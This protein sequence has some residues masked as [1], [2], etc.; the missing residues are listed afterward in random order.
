LEKLVVLLSPEECAKQHTLPCLQEV[1]QQWRRSGNSSSAGRGLSIDGVGHSGTANS[2]P[3]PSTA[4]HSSSSR[5]Q[6]ASGVHTT[7]PRVQLALTGGMDPADTRA[8][9]QLQQAA[10][11]M[12]A[13][14]PGLQV[15]AGLDTYTCPC[16]TGEEE[17]RWFEAL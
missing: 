8:L 16:W 17:A 10:A 5:E 2:A 1:L 4:I 6:A 11:G 9:K 7:P 12:A 13:A 14:L 3:L 15:T